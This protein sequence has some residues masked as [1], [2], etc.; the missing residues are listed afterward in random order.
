MKKFSK[1]LSIILSIMLVI[2]IVPITASAAT[3]GTCGDNLS[4]T[5]D[6]STYTLTISGTGAMD[7]YSS[8]NRP[9]ESYMNS[10]E[11]V[12]VSD[13]ITTIGS[14]AFDWCTSLISIT[15]PDSVITI[16]DYAFY[17]CYSLISAT[18]PDSVTTIGNCAFA[19]CN[20]LISVAIP[21][22]VTTIGIYAFSGCYALTSA[23]IG[24]SVR[25]I[26]NFAFALCDSLTSVIIGDSVTTIGLCTFHDCT[27]LTDVYYLGTKEQWNEISINSGNYC[28][29]GATIHC[30]SLSSGTCGDNLTWTYDD[31][32]GTLTISGEGDMY[33]YEYGNCPWERYKENIQNVVIN[34]GVTTIGDYAFYF[35][36]AMTSVII[37]EGVTIIGTSAF[38]SCD[39]L[40]SVTIPDSVTAIGDA[41]FHWCRSLKSV[42]VP[43]GVTK[44][45]DSAFANCKEII[46]D[47]NNKYF[48]SD[49]YGVLFNKDKTTLLQYPSGNTRKSYTIPNSVKTIGD[50]SFS[51]NSERLGEY[52]D[53]VSLTS[54][55]IP[56]SVIT[57]GDSAFECCTNLTSVTVPDSITT[58]GDSAFYSC[59]SLLDVYYSGAKDQWNKIFIGSYNDDLTSARI[60]YN[61]HM[62]KYNSVVSPPTCTLQ[63]YTTY[64]CA[65]GDS[66]VSDYVSEAPHN[67]EWVTLSVASCTTNG[68]M[69]G[70]C[71]DC[72]YYE[73]KTT[74]M[75]DHA[76]NDGDGY[77]D[78]CPE[79]LDST[80]ECECNCHKSGISKFFFN[81]ILFFQKLFGSNKECACGVAH[82]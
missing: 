82:Y 17:N 5:Y 2:S 78:T 25:I 67:L 36:F 49:E 42:V 48:S 75:T 24:D 56:D 20:S 39:S 18:I 45:G 44:I 57:I 28:L 69:H 37:P 43:S 31:T 29:T 65:C 51:P 76:D 72:T 54:I 52:C 79:I 4:W 64:T 8:Y 81:L 32:T 13:G 46:V 66:Y 73:V 11:N 38:Q 60:H 58:I 77:C 33:N 27:S 10:I 59:D 61:Y 3:S 68:V 7:D 40:T 14:M 26:G 6:S 41:A 22:R 63:G 19:E 35:C 53:Y 9:W 70:Y 1:I 55:I 21:D 23:T 80:V 34:D 71:Q 50:W 62:H 15:I 74:P 12:I 47:N 16:G 30:K